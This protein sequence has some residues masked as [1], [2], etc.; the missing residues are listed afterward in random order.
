MPT[1]AGPGRIGNKPRQSARN[2]SSLSLLLAVALVLANVL[3]VAPVAAQS[4]ESFAT[5]SLVPADALLY[6]VVPLVDNDEQ[7][8][9]GMT[10]LRR[11]GL[12]SDLDALTGEVLGAEGEEELPMELFLGGE[13]AMVV[14][15][16]AMDLLVNQAAGGM[17]GGAAP[18]AEPTYTEAG[19]AFLIT[20]ESPAFIALAIESAIA[21][22]AQQLGVEVE[23]TEYDGVSITY[24]TVPD[25]VDET[26][27]ATARIGDVVL[28]AGFPA[29]LEPLIETSSGD[30]ESLADLDAFGQARAALDQ[31]HLLFGYLN[32]PPADIFEQALG[33]AG[34]P[35]TMPESESAPIGFLVAADEPGFR[36]ETV[37]IGTGSATANTTNLAESQL[38]TTTP[39][40]ALILFSGLDLAGTGILDLTASLILGASGLV[41]PSA[42]PGPTEDVVADQFEQLAQIMGVNFRTDLLLQLTGTYGFWAEFDPETGTVTTLFTSDVDDVEA[43]SGALFQVTLLAQSAGSGQMTVTTRPVGETDRVFSIL[44][45]DATV[46]RVEY[47]FIG[48]TMVVGLGEAVDAYAGG[49]ESPLAGSE[50]FDVIM[51][52]LPEATTGLMYIDLEQA[53]PLLNTAAD[54]TG[55][56]DLAADITGASDEAS[57][58]AQPAD[59]RSGDAHPDCAQFASQAEAQAAYDAFAPGTFQ[60]DEDFDGEACE[61]FFTLDDEVI[62]TPDPV[63]GVAVTEMTSFSAFGMVA[64]DEDGNSRTSSLLLVTEPD[65]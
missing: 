15:N 21:N 11:A 8:Q 28:A 35:V 20:S 44:T 25:G 61:D 33:E 17:T 53:I 48:E 63:P 50:S 27:M 37:S 34:L 19:L 56:D 64:F 40:D 29:D 47:G 59:T 49:P 31:D 54:E 1:A 36:L 22:T 24:V 51:S 5:A 14:T 57:L 58:G 10:L 46:P 45:G 38:V 23:Q 55:V 43:V 52:A 12:G 13:V 2:R 16:T 41:A 62:V 42:T 32:P 9:Q 3:A 7:W 4:T 60:L 39:D 18:G 26:P 65:E 30:R 6:T